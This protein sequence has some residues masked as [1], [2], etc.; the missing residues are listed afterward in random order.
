MEQD[1]QQALE[2]KFKQVDNKADELFSYYETANKQ[3]QDKMNE[4]QKTVD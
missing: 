3:A 1:F 4:H 2:T